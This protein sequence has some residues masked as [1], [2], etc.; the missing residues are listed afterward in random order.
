VTLVSNEN[1]S[2]LRVFERPQSS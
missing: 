1:Q 2:K